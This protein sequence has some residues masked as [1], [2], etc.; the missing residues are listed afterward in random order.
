MRIVLQ[1][2]HLRQLPYRT[3]TFQQGASLP[4]MIMHKCDQVANSTRRLAVGRGPFTPWP[5][6]M[7]QPVT[8]V[9]H[10]FLFFSKTLGPRPEQK[11]Q[12]VLR[13][14]LLKSLFSTILGSSS[15]SKKQNIESESPLT[16]CWIY[17]LLEGVTL[18][19]MCWGRICLP[20][21]VLH[22]QIGD[23]VPSLSSLPLFPVGKHCLEAHSRPLRMVVW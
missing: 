11:V 9:C 23:P 1:C 20:P 10:F 7:G 18:K 17:L 15:L 21:N 13:G 6:N 14:Q 3:N 5:W 4:W 16:Q 8:L 2:L 19:D 22:L 12:G